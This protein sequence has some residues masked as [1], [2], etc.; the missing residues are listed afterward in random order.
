MLIVF[1]DGL[2]NIT[3]KRNSWRRLPDMP[4]FKYAF[5]TVVVDREI[6]TIGG[7]DLDNHDAYLDLV[8]VYHPAANRWRVI[9]TD[10]DTK[11]DGSSNR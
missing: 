8:E 9:C 5:S 2:R 7:Y 6:Y 3:R 10:A 11:N 1:P 4:T